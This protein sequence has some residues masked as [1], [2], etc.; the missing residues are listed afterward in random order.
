MREIVK[1]FSLRRN[2]VIS[3]SYLN[4]QKGRLSNPSNPD[5]DF[6]SKRYIITPKSRQMLLKWEAALMKALKN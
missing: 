3:G 2:I 6:D 5:P 4:Y 1:S